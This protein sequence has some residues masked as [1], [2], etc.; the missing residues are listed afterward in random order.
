VTVRVLLADDDHAFRD[1][2]ARLLVT[3]GQAEVVAT[4][5]DGEEAVR[6]YRELAPDVV[7]MDLV[8]PGCDGIEATRR[9]VAL[10]AEARIVAIT[11]GEDYRA[12]AL[13]LAAGARGCLKKGPDSVTLA[14]LLLALAAKPPSAPEPPRTS[15]A[16]RSPIMIAAAFVWPPITSGMIDASATRRSASPWTR[17]ARSTTLIR[18]E[19][20]RHVP[21]GW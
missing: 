19:P 16:A 20:M 18:S 4:A 5:S 17:S 13:C 11:S 12:L 9:I 10:D 14:P 7:L 15:S 3:S 8:M 21:A 1:R 6:R 2:I